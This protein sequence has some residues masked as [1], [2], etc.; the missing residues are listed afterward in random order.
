MLENTL[1]LYG[2]ASMRF[3]CP[4]TIRSSSPEASG[5]NPSGTIPE[6]WFSKSGHHF[7]ICLRRYL[8]GRNEK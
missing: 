6:I 2:S 1:C 4:K 3:I 5:G 8:E 7:R